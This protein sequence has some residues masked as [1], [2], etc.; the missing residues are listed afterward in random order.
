MHILWSGCLLMIIIMMIIIIIIA[1]MMC[2][3]LHCYLVSVHQGHIEN[4]PLIFSFIV[5]VLSLSVSFL[6]S[7]Q[8]LIFLLFF[9]FFNLF[10]INCYTPTRRTDAWDKNHHFMTSFSNCLN[11]FSR[12]CIL[13]IGLI[14][15]LPRH[16]SCYIQ[17]LYTFTLFLVVCWVEYCCLIGIMLDLN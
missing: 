15:T 16:H 7:S 9:S 2:M 14:E 8:T 3:M 11:A 5:S 1:T 13:T 17:I 6:R 4:E 12:R 10:I